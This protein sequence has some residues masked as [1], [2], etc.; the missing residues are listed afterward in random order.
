[1][2]LVLAWIGVVLFGGLFL[3]SATFNNALLVHGFLGRK[4]GPSGIPLIGGI[5]G[6]IALLIAPV[7]G[8]ARFWWVPLFADYGCLPSL[9]ALGFLLWRER[10]SRS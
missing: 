3:V 10:R 4:E 8:V 2:T 5:A 1:M 6:A 9:I 7:D